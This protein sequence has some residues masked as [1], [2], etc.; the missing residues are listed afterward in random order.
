MLACGLCGVRERVRCPLSAVRV[1]RGDR[2]S[3]V[4]ARHG[5]DEKETERI[6]LR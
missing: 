4:P 2:V 5:F 1:G 3:E 6:L